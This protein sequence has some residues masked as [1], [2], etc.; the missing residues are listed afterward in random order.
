VIPRVEFAQ[1]MARLRARRASIA[2]HDS[3]TRWQAAGVESF[4]VTEHSSTRRDRH[5]E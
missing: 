3:A 1:V 5:G 4:L 2:E